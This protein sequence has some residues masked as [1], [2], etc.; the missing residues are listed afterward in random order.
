MDSNQDFYTLKGYQLKQFPELT[1]AM[2]DYLEMIFRLLSDSS[3]SGCSLLDAPLQGTSKTPV[4]RIR[5]L[6]EQLHVQPSSASKMVHN[7]ADA[8]YV[9]FPR[10][11]YIVLTEKGLMTGAYLLRRHEVLHTFLCLLNHSSNELEQV[12]KIEHFIN[13]STLKNLEALTLKLMQKNPSKT[14]PAALGISE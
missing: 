3:D 11:G 12:E 2:E 9:R 1:Y 14:P 7:L 5:N 8:G 6:A 10:Y 13:D 4:V